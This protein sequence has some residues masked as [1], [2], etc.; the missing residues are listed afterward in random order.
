MAPVYADHPFALIPT[1]S[2]PRLKNGEPVPP[3]DIFHEL[4]TDMTLVHNLIIR[5]LNAI[6]LQAPHVTAPADIPPFTRFI[7][8][9]HLMIAIHHAGEESMF[10]PEVERMSGVVGVMD[11]E[12][13]EHEQ[14]HAGLD[15][16]K[17]YVDAVVAGKEAWDGKRVVSV[18]EGF[19]DV[20]TGHLSGEVKSL[21][22]L[23][24]FGEVK[25]AGVMKEA[26][27]EAEAGMK[28]LGA[29]GLAWAFQQIDQEYEEGTWKDWPPAPWPIKF[30][31]KSVLPRFYPDALKFAACDRNGKM[32]PLYALREKDTQ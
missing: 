3:V 2:F 15:E 11:K 16:L 4:A 29:F 14:F 5:G 32:Q 21:E 8:A 31:A 1:P 18:I 27:K 9:W 26:G 12:K 13:E 17:G 20:L 30:A 22:E 25:M 7:L 28:A 19:G 6:V 24:R 10:F 23:R